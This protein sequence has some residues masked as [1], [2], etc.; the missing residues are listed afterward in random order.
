MNAVATAGEKLPRIHFLASVI[1]EEAKD[2]EGI[3][4]N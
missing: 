1:M 3:G 4:R 2:I